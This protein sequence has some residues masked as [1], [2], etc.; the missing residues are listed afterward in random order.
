MVLTG[1]RSY[2]CMISL[3]N[4]GSQY[5][6]TLNV[7]I[8]RDV[9]SNILSTPS[10]QT[11]PQS[12]STASPPALRLSPSGIKYSHPSRSFNFRLPV[13]CS[14]IS[15]MYLAIVGF[16]SGSSFG[17]CGSRLDLNWRGVFLVGGQSGDELSRDKSLI[18]QGVLD[19][20]V[21]LLS[22]I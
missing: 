4:T 17:S 5:P 18:G 20:M 16:L 3:A 10:S 12:T 13:K 6:N 9:L 7:P 11:L 14:I 1:E 21:K 15:R 19:E 22:V 8:I 2:C